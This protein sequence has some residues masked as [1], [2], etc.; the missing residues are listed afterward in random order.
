[1][2]VEF[3]RT[4]RVGPCAW[5]CRK[6]AKIHSIWS[7]VEV[8]SNEI[9]AFP[10]GFSVRDHVVQM[11]WSSEIPLN[12][13]L[14]REGRG[15]PAPRPLIETAARLSRSPNADINGADAAVKS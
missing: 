13:P 2:I 5:S 3:V 1:M 15:Y 12:L 9:E 10:E 8:H 4:V 7:I 11:S 14:A 6:L